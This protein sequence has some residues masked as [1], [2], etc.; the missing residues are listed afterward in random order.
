MNNNADSRPLAYSYLRF[1][2]PEQA[3]GTS[4]RRQIEAAEEYCR[5]NNLRLDASL[6]DEGVSAHKGKHLEPASAL[7]GFLN[8]VQAGEVKPGSYLLI[9]NFDR[10]SR[11]HVVKALSLFLTLTSAGITIVTLMDGK[12]YNMETLE[13]N[14]TQLLISIIVMSRAYEESATKSKRVG[15]AWRKKKQAAREDGQAMTA[16]CP[17]WIKLVGG[18]KKGRYEIIPDRAAIVAQ[19]F[20]DTIAGDGRRKIAARLNEAGVTTWGPGRSRGKYWHDSYVQKLLSNH[21]TYGRYDKNGISIPNYFPAA[22]TEA[23]F[24]RAAAVSSQRAQPRGSAGKF[25]HNVLSGLVRCHACASVMIYIDKGKR[26]RPRFICA[27]A[28]A[29]AGCTARQTYKYSYMLYRT[30]DLYRHFADATAF[31]T[32]QTGAHAETVIAALEAKLKQLSSE[33]TNLIT[34]IQKGLT[35]AAIEDRYRLVQA[36]LAKVR[37]E[38]KAQRLLAATAVEMTPDLVERFDMIMTKIEHEDPVVRYQERSKLNA[39]LKH[40][41][42]RIVVTPDNEIRLVMNTGFEQIGEDNG[43]TFESYFDPATSD[44]ENFE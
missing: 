39:R 28:H 41:I 43:A 42:E 38:I 36:D 26:S 7:G 24:F 21:S 34:V 13:T 32:D 3:K 27:S 20:E 15:D 11:E 31:A 44:Y 4:K 1:S 16:R 23:V 12:V 22:V 29:S 17:G 8:R 19:I 30:I 35:G 9:E 33:E 18:P 10:L 14:Q 6:R 25:F 2:T 37:K 40:Y 5:L